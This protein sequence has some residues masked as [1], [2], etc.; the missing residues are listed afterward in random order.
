MN[1]HRQMILVALGLWSL[2]PLIAEARP[3]GATYVAGAIPF[4]KVG[5]TITVPVTLTNTGDLTWEKNSAFRLSY[6]WYWH[7]SQRVAVWD[8][9]RT[10]LF[11]DVAKGQ[12]ITLTAR[13]TAPSAP[14]TYALKWDMIHEHVVWFSRKTVR[15][16]EQTVM[17]APADWSIGGLLAALKDIVTCPRPT[18]YDVPIFHVRPGSIVDVYGCGFGGVPG[19]LRLVGD[20]PN[21]YLTLTNLDW[22]DDRV[23]GTVPDVSRVVGQT[24]NV[25]IVT[26]TQLE[27][28]AFSVKFWATQDLLVLPH[29]AME[30]VRC[31]NGV[32]N[33]SSCEIDGASYGGH[34][35]YLCCDAGY[36][37]IDSFSVTLKN[38]WGLSHRKDWRPP[39]FNTDAERSTVNKPE[40]V[41]R[42]AAS[43]TV[44][45]KWSTDAGGHASYFGLIE[46]VGPVGVPYR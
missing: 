38:G 12:S 24:A 10:T 45:I 36:D 25:H 28:G 40:V 17:V 39:F 33:L 44:S 14:G 16:L 3:Y 4:L 1:R 32:A 31:E 43:T 9:P 7:G 37:G 19:E 21:G 27:S 26:H 23:M 29:D 46:I 18:I 30:V 15:M 8:G 34:H 35:T 22:H 41:N 11:Q 5:Q 2:F 13:V 6:H 42:S 20:F